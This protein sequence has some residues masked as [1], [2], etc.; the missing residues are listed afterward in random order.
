MPTYE[1]VCQACSADYEERR[2]MLQ[3]DAPSRCPECGSARVRRRLSSVII[4]TASNGASAGG[5]C[6]CSSGGTC[7][8]RAAP[9]HN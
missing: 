1:F 3:A 7:G 4:L 6:A 2:P 9:S 8:C 5:G